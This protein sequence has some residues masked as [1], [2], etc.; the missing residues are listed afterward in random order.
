M[1]VLKQ[2]TRERVYSFEQSLYFAAL[3][4]LVS[5]SG[6]W[7]RA[8]REPGFVSDVPCDAGKEG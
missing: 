4:G 8:E 6:S 2:N 3:L 1:Y 5:A 7:I